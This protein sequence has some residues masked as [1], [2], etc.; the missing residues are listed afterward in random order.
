MRSLDWEL[1]HGGFIPGGT[2]GPPV[3]IAAPPGELVLVDVAAGGE[4]VGCYLAHCGL[5]LGVWVFRLGLVE[6][7][8]IGRVYGVFGNGK[9]DIAWSFQ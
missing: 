5:V 7:E 3:E 8:G 2:G 4:D 1:G 6:R 9:R